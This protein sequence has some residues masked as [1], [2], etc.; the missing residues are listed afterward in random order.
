MCHQFD[1]NG[2]SDMRQLVDEVKGVIYNFIYFK[3][4]FL[5]FKFKINFIRLII[6]LAFS[7]FKWNYHSFSSLLSRKYII[8]KIE[9]NSRNAY[10][11][12]I[13]YFKLFENQ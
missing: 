3:F 5:K 6:N 7:D 12:S 8:E 1:E 4:K 2:V 10:M 13:R 11:N 9:T